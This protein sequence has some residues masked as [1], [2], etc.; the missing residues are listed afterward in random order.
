[1]YHGYI[2]VWYYPSSSYL[3]ES[4]KCCALQL[5]Q[6][7]RRLEMVWLVSMHDQCT[8][9]L[10]P[11]AFPT[12]IFYACIS[13]IKS[14]ACVQVHQRASTNC[15]PWSASL[16]PSGKASSVLFKDASSCQSCLALLWYVWCET[17]TSGLKCRL[18]VYSKCDYKANYKSRRRNVYDK[19]KWCRQSVLFSEK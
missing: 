19:M 14:A 16:V 2:L 3:I 12:Y 17:D 4:C 11:T 18:L 1:M 6:C 15:G 10:L 7:N 5:L 9:Y 8:T 13:K